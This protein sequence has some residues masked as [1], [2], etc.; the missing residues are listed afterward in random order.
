MYERIVTPARSSD[1]SIRAM[2][3]TSMRR[4]VAGRLAT[5]LPLSLAAFTWGCQG[6]IVAPESSGGTSAGSSTT[7]TGGSANNAGA[8]GSTGGS[9][10]VSTGG[11][12][13]EP[14]PVDTG[15]VTG[16]DPQQLPDGVPANSRVL[17]LA[18]DE[19]DRTLA[20]LLYLPV[21]E[22]S[23]FPAEQSNLG[24]YVGYAELRV[25]E[26]LLTEL[27]RSASSLA[28][29]VVSSPEAYAA[30]VGCAPSAAGCRDQFIDG[31]GMRAFRRP[32]SE[33]EQTRYRALFERGAELVASGDGFRDGVQLTLEAMLVSPKL[34]YR[35]ESGDGTSDALGARLSGFEL[36][37][38]LSFM[39]A[40]TTPDAELLAA[41]RD[42]ALS[43][44]EGIATQARRLVAGSGFAARV[45]S[46]HERWMQLDDL[47]SLVK[48]E[49]VFPSFSPEL[50][51]SMRSEAV[52]FINAVTLESNGTVSELLTARF[53]FV[54]QRLAPLYGL[55]GSFGSELV[56]VEHAPE[57]GRLGLFTQAAFLSSHSSSSSATSPILRGVFLLRR[58]ACEDIPDPPAGAQMQE[59]ATE[60]ATPISTT[61]EYF[62]WKTSLPSC[63]GCHALINP[64]GFAF[65]EFD[66]LGQWRD[67]ERGAPIDSSGQL[68]LGGQ[69]LAFGGA[70]EL[71]EGL[72]HQPQVHA[73]YAKNWLEF[74]YGRPQEEGDSRALGL[75]AQSLGAGGFS[76]RDLA[77]ALTERPAFDHLPRKA[78]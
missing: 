41:A 17:R 35:I 13:S 67:E 25:S 44:A 55:Q 5:T 10:A 56:R 74:A 71:L 52:R 42:G 26:R 3:E 32:L 70:S 7:G 76:I 61:R 19:Y 29:R 9:S 6:E 47:G 58:V 39:L 59:P 15:G 45:L 27:E 50:V 66:G 20:D 38:R 72:A 57:S 28:E 4:R 75:A 37:T 43:T 40:G 36:S 77:V 62:T 64:T 11:S 31:F 63:A 53:G 78:E 23:N 33:P 8:S 49:T 12:G 16:V 60:P 51:D 34:L 46:F 65:E 14:N 73:C 22:S 2:I 48:D 30:V 21:A 69:V 18:Y 1:P 54:D 24:P 68:E